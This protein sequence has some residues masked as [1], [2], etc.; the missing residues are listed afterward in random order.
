VFTL[1][2]AGAAV[3][4]FTVSTTTTFDLNQVVVRG[5]GRYAGYEL[6]DV[7]TRRESPVSSL[8]TTRDIDAR[9]RPAA[10]AATRY[11]GHLAGLAC[12]NPIVTLRPGRRYRVFL[13]TDGSAEV[14][15]PL[16]AGSTSGVA[17][18]ATKPLRYTY[19]AK[20]VLYQATDT[21]AVVRLPMSPAPSTEYVFYAGVAPA[22]VNGVPGTAGDVVVTGCITRRAAPC[23]DRAAY[24]VTSRSNYALGSTTD[25]GGSVYAG[26]DPRHRDV[27]AEARL[28]GPCPGTLTLLLITLDHRQSTAP[29]PH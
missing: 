23:R 8:L 6:W 20:S 4:D 12:C 17:I 28:Q 11:N 16:R 13:V 5:T 18:T 24:S 2:A 14:R 19:T 7:T 25:T 10:V 27:R 29:T 21:G 1:T 26:V 9:Y 3:A 15:A 22:V